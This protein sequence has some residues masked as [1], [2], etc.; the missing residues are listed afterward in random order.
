MTI[1]LQL[2]ETL[3]QELWFDDE[4]Q[5]ILDFYKYLLQKN[6]NLKLKYILKEIEEYNSKYPKHL[7]TDEEILELTT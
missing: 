5:L 3:I 6:K 1:T 7:L 2:P 4:K